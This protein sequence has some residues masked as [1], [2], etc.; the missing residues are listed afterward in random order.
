MNLKELSEKL[1]KK[2]SIKCLLCN[3][4]IYKKNLSYF[5]CNERRRHLNYPCNESILFDFFI[6]QTYNK[7]NIEYSFCHTYDNNHIN[8]VEIYDN[9]LKSS[10]L[11]IIDLIY[12]KKK[13][14]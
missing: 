8:Y 2:E 12:D 9:E 6:G 13:Y 1:I 11:K 10:K 4:D 14:N 7:K 5:S 3:I